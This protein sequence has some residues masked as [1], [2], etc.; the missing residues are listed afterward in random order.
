MMIVTLCFMKGPFSNHL[1]AVLHDYG[2]T[3]NCQVPHLGHRR[4]CLEC[5]GVDGSYFIPSLNSSWWH[6]CQQVTGFWCFSRWNCCIK[7]QL[8]N[9][10]VWLSVFRPFTGSGSAGERADARKPSERQRHG[11]RRVDVFWGGSSG[12]APA[13]YLYQVLLILFKQ[14]LTF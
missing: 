13:A 9:P 2:Q 11:G 5:K 1:F 12:A 10:D 4:I 14:Q 3:C 7:D 6:A 8:L